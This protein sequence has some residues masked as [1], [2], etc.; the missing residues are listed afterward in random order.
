MIFCALKTVYWTSQ[1][2]KNI[3]LLEAVQKGRENAIKLSIPSYR[4]P[5]RYLQA[6][7]TDG[8]P[9]SSAG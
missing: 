1:S 5:I 4:T 9:A 2:Q 7:S 3:P 6:I 8:D